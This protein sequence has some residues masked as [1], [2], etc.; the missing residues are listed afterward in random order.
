MSPNLIIGKG[1]IVNQAYF[2]ISIPLAIFGFSAQGKI[3]ART[4]QKKIGNALDIFSP[5]VYDD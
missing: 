4:S 5:I 1:A 2:S 3:L